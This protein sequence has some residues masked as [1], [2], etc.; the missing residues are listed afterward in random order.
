MNDEVLEK[1]RYPTGR[2]QAPPV[3]EK[4]DLERFINDLEDLP[5]NLRKVLNGFTKEMLDE[6]YKPGGWTAR[7]LVHHLADSHMNAYFRFKLALTEAVPVIRPY[8][9]KAWAELSDARNGHPELS[10]N[11]LESLHRRFVVLLRSMNADDFNR[12]FFHPENKREYPLK[13]VLAI[14]SWH[15]KHHLEHIRIV[16]RKFAVA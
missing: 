1:L 13:T 11:L 10:L 6:S 2:F 8:D 16:K 15:G 14:Y 4:E 5:G 7:Q 12:C 3:I 9:E